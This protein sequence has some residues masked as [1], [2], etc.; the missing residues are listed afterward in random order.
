MLL[1]FQIAIGTSIGVF[2]G[3]FAVRYIWFVCSEAAEEASAKLLA[4]ILV[5][6]VF[7]GLVGLWYHL[8][9]PK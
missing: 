3:G 9:P 5:I 7:I 1:I 2:I 8:S 6:L 4:L